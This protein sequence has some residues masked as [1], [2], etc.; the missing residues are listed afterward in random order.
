MKKTYSL[1]IA[2]FALTV[3]YGQKTIHDANAE[4]R[5]VGSFHG[6][7]VA[8]GI[9]LILT[10]GTTQEVAVSAAT[11]EFRDRIE[12]KV[13]G[14]ILR[15]QY[16]NKLR[17][18]NSRKE[19]KH[20]KAYVSYTSLDVLNAHTGA[21]VRIEGTLKSP[22]LKM[23]VHTGATVKGKID[24]DDLSVDQ[25]TGSEVTFTG[26]AD[27][28]TVEGDTGS[29]FHG[30]ELLTSNCSVTASTGSGVSITVNKELSVKANTGGFV[31]YKGDA[32][33]REIRTNSGGQVTKI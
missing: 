3:G 21:E 31:K 17:A 11:T 20:L 29:M 10:E 1:I 24:V 8:T 32:T 23:E 27:K 13:E 12:T 15:I 6:I 5:T 16:D 2:F 25:G 28:L 9:E 26:R 14:G 18:A 22:A 4:K 7:H 19:K 33:I 30:I